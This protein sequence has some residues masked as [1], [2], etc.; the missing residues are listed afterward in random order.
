MYNFQFQFVT[1]LM[2]VGINLFLPHQ[3]HALSPED[4]QSLFNGCFQLIMDCFCIGVVAGMAIK[5]INRS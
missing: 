1:F 5:M 2:V 4:G 3:C